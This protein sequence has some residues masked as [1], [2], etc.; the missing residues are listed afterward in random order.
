[1]RNT[2]L[3]VAVGVIMVFLFGS[4]LVQTNTAN[5]LPLFGGLYLRRLMS[6]SFSFFAIPSKV[7]ELDLVV[8]K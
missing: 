3:V 4:S 5:A 1:M 6:N 8:Q 2:E 7:M